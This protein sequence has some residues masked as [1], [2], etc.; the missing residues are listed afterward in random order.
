L[1]I[2]PKSIKVFSPIIEQ[3]KTIVWNGPAGVFEWEAF[4]KGTRAML[5][6][7]INATSNG[8]TTIIGNIYNHSLFIKSKFK[9]L[10]QAV[11]TQPVFVK[12]GMPR[13]K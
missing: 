13:I 9:Q 8:A 4:S 7:V 11:V 2:G 5:D 3:A 6:A 10:F 12:S 1:D